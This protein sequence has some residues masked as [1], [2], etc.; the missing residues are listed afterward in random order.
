MN[1]YDQAPKGDAYTT[2]LLRVFTDQGVEGVGTLDYAAPDAAMIEAL[3]ALI[4]ADPLA[5]YQVEARR[6]VGAAARFQAL[7][8]RYPFPDSALFD[9]IG[10]L[11]GSPLLAVVG[12]LGAGPRRGLR[13]PFD[14]AW[15]FLA[16]TQKANLFW[17]EEIFPQDPALYARLREKM[18]KAGMRT[19]IADGEDM[20]SV[21]DSVPT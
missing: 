3:R 13:R 15:R 12:T 1:S 14:L 8:A 7:L 20:R 21:E 19:L 5:L 16:E 4:G 10:R 11:L 9:L 18:R 2:R 17:I 6:I